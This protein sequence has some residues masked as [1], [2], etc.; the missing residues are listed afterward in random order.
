MVFTCMAWSGPNFGQL[1]NAVYSAYLFT[2]QSYNATPAKWWDT[3]ST[4]GKGPLPFVP[5]S[6]ISR[7]I[8]VR[9][10][11]DQAAEA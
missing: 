9:A 5:L 4:N 3:M 11:P 8:S 7:V 2:Y 1:C 6:S 10:S